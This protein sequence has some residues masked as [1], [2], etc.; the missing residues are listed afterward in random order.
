[1]LDSST[2]QSPNPTLSRT[3]PSPSTDTPERASPA[4][5]APFSPLNFSPSIAETTAVV[6]LG[7]NGWHADGDVE[8][9]SR[10]TRELSV[11]DERE[12]NSTLQRNSNDDADGVLDSPSGQ[13]DEPTVDG[14]DVQIPEDQPRHARQSLERR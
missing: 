1:M 11:I 5:G 3:H 12:T 13:D 6:A 8:D 7:Q 10:A 14:E 9:I 2:P 4:K